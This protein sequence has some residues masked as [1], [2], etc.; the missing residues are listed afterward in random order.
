M[1]EI[2]VDI[3]TSLLETIEGNYESR[4]VDAVEEG[5]TCRINAEIALG[6]SWVQRKL[7]TYIDP[8]I[9][10]T[11][12]IADIR[13]PDSRSSEWTK[14]I[15]LPGSKTN[16]IIFSHLFEVEQNI[17]ST[18]Q[19]TPDFNPNLKAN[20]II[21]CD[22]IEQMRGFLRLIS[23][24]VDDSTHIKYEVSCHGQ[25]ADFFTTIAERKLNE[26]NFDEYNHTLSSGGVVDSWATQI[27]KNGSPQAFAYG[28]GYVYAMIDKGVSKVQNITNFPVT[29]MTPCL[30]AKTV[31]DKIFTNAAYTFT[32]DSYFNN[33]NFKRLIVTPP[34]GLSLAA[35]TIVGRQFQASRITTAQTVTIGNKLIFQNDSTSGNFDNGNNY[36][37]TTGEYTSPIAGDFV[38]GAELIAVFT[39]DPGFLNVI[40][41]Y[42]LYVN[43][44]IK[45][46]TWE[47]IDFSAPLTH[48]STITFN[49]IIVQAGDVVSIRF[50]G[51]FDTVGQEYLRNVDFI[52]ELQIGSYF[53]NDQN[54]TTFGYGDAIDF[55]SFL[56]SE[57]KQSE[58]LM[59][60]VKM[61]NL[62]IEPDQDN[63][64]MLRC[65][66]RD[67]FYNGSQVDWTA[68]LDY[69]QAV[70]IVPMGELEANP[71]LFTYK[72]GTDES[73]K[74]YQENYQSTY[75]SRTYKVDNNFIKTEKKIETIF[76]PTQIKNYDNRQRNF[77]LSYVASEKDSDMRIFYYSGL[78][79]GVSWRLY[80]SVTAFSL[81]T[82]LP[83]TIHY[84]S[85]SN[86]TFDILFGMPKELGLGAGY[87]YGNSNLVNNFYYKFLTEITNKNSKLIRAY[88]RITLKDYL[89]LSF[90]DSYFFEGQYWRLN[91]IEDYNPN[92]DGVY[93]CEFLLQQFIES[94]TI[95]N[96]TVGSGTGGGQSEETYGDIY[97]SGR[98]QI[99][100]GIRKVSIGRGESTGNGVFVGEG[101][102][103]SPTNT[104][105]SG[106]GLTD[107][108]FGTETNGSVALICEDFE[109]NKSDTLYVGN[110]E[111][112]PSFL[113]GGSTQTVTANYTT[114][115][116]D[117]LILCDTTA[118]SI[119]ITLPIPVSGKHYIFKKIAAAHSMI[120]DTADSSLIDGNATHTNNANNGFEWIT[121]NGTNYYI[122][123]HQ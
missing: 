42:G 51:L 32:N 2:Y 68:K 86:P 72:Q 105:N 17:T 80:A 46:V 27:Y 92:G 43:G 108:V 103:S 98:Y 94:A 38:F 69:S 120:I 59:S 77:V 119:T 11:R 110:Y 4:I 20:I 97:P 40:L 41:E 34:N 52:F 8:D 10:I 87:K 91:K 73:N 7:D 70:D 71:Y 31:V 113:S 65:V 62:Y 5:E 106:L 55:G 58:I 78:Q 60:F 112:Y 102:V 22:G 54:A 61:F 35:A 57:L 118:G 107:V 96:K 100:P 90:S 13:E 28:E 48:T 47:N 44:K 19:F 18:V 9:L 24:K 89:N 66:P 121:N 117:W 39:P 50:K 64:K 114:T 53:L 122:I 15:E 101:I 37:P 115:A 63:P 21:Y 45:D 109:V 95:T 6:G 29:S 83:L 36:N 116:D 85:L 74:E 3:P 84:D 26:L 99:R 75:G 14:T 93:L 56:N 30:Y 82:T 79:T 88:F 76:S 16:N 49:D 67:D 1:I 104:N 33:A 111:M 81:R 123:S 23:I 25:S 12:S